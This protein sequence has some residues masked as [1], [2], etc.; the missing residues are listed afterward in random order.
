MF[1]S[2]AVEG[3]LLDMHAG[4]Y[5][6][7]TIKLYDFTLHSLIKYLEDP[8]IEKVKLEELNRFMANLR[9]RQPALSGPYLDNHWKSVRAF[10]RW[11]NEALGF[12][13]PDTNLARPKY[14]FA[15]IVPYSEAA[16]KRM[17]Q[18]CDYSRKFKRYNTKEYR[19]HRTRH[20]KR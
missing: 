3:F 18:A 19:L 13:R 9:T 4:Q 5:A 7:A 11:C 20:L 17:I 2:K 10:F 15:E 6:A 1:L 12:A 14:K 16:I 8:P